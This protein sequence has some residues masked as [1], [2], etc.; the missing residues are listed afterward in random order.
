MK[1]ELLVT[2]RGNTEFFPAGTI[3]EDPLP[4]EIQSEVALNRGTVRVIEE[5][6][7]PPPS[8]PEPDRRDR[9]QGLQLDES[10]A[11]MEEE[12]PKPLVR[13]APKKKVI[14]KKRV[15]AKRKAKLEVPK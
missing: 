12:P 5:T 8:P 11:A 6:A 15:P 10:L 7:P 3:F 14:P 4:V 13:T 9:T 2:L 1:V